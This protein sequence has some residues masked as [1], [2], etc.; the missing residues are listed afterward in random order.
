MLRTGN[1]ETRST[2]P[3]TYSDFGF[4]ISDFRCEAAVMAFLLKN[5]PTSLLDVAS[6]SPNRTKAQGNRVL[7]GDFLEI[8][9]S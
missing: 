1:I 7:T 2:K 3:E 6:L 9:T 5:E 8:L 4:G